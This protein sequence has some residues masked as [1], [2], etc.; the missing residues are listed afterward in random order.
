LALASS[1]VQGITSN[2]APKANL[3]GCDVMSDTSATCNG[4]NLG[5]T[6]GDAHGT[7]NGCGITQNSNVPAVS[8]PYSGLASNIPA[9]TC[10]SYPQE[11]KKGSLPASN[12]WSGSYSV[13]NAWNGVSPSYIGNVYY[14]IVCGDQQLT[15]NTTITAG[16]NNA[17]LVIE[18]GQLDT[19]GYTLLTSGLTVVFTAPSAYY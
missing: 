6:I 3:N 18:N 5:A 17:V 14:Y 2:G 4:H 19:N 7:N 9:N 13:G 16:S 10:G 15:A 1:G 12:Q 11:P 8:D